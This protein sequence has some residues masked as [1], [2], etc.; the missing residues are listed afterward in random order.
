VAAV[1]EQQCMM[2]TDVAF[3]CSVFSFVLEALTYTELYN[4]VAL[5]I[6]TTF[7]VNDT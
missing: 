3:L 4:Q 7:S 1:L 5:Q 6:K 2:K